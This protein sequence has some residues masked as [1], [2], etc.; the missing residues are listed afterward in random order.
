MRRRRNIPQMHTWAPPES[1]SPAPRRFR[2][3]VP[4]PVP[5]WPSRLRRR[6]RGGYGCAPR[7]RRRRPT[8]SPGLGPRGRWRRAGGWRSS[9][10]G[11]SGAARSTSAGSPSRATWAEEGSP[12]GAG[13]PGPAAGTA[14]RCSTAASTRPSCSAPAPTPSP[15]SSPSTTTTGM[16][17]RSLRSCGTCPSTTGRLTRRPSRPTRA[18]KASRSSSSTVLGCSGLASSGSRFTGPFHIT[19]TISARHCF[20]SRIG[21]LFP[22]RLCSIRRPGLR[23]GTV[24]T[25]W[26]AG[27]C[28]LLHTWL[29]MA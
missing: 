28:G 23:Y 18:T 6:R 22:Q 26:P 2:S 13:A 11:R 1:P 7:R 16:D 10:R 19:T 29:H 5:H 4:T 15:S 25:S 24:S 17:G 12:A 3:L 8:C 21:G 14:T 9:P 27:S 20:H